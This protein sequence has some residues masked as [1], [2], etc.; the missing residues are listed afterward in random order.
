MKYY[1]VKF[2]HTDLAGWKKFVNAQ[3]AYLEEMIA[4]DKLIVSGPV[5]NDSQ[6]EKEAYLIFQVKDRAELQGLLENDSYWYEG[7]VA[8]YSL[9]EWNPMFG[10]L[11]KPKNKLM[12]TLSKLLNR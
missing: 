9:D 6:V 4:A 8:D 3:I 5:K 1:I 2:V 11:Q 7:L 12:I 10:A